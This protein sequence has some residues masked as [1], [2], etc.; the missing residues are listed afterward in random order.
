MRAARG[1]YARKARPPVPRGKNRPARR[2]Q[3]PPPAAFLAGQKSE[4]RAEKAKQS[5]K[6]APPKLGGAALRVFYSMTKT[7]TLFLS[8]ETSSTLSWIGASDSAGTML[9]LQP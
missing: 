6:A 4:N 3:S 8:K 7:V 5:E 2:K 9:C 1:V